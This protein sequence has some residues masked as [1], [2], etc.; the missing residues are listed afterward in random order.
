MAK[1]KNILNIKADE[2]S[3]GQ[4]L[5]HKQ[6]SF[7]RLSQAD[8]KTPSQMTTGAE[9]SSDVKTTAVS[10]CK[11]SSKSDT[12]DGA[13]VLRALP[14]IP[15]PNEEITSAVTTFKR[16]LAREWKPA[17]IPPPRGTLIVS[18]IVEI[19]GPNGRCTL[20]VQAA[21]H[22]AQSRWVSLAMGVRRIYPKKKGPRGGH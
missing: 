14:P 16:T 10:T 3:T 4:H 11:A 22:P 2:S 12:K 5:P 18:G 17:G 6:I 21:Y 7:H 19:K 15:Q 8:E 20:E 9:P 1:L 13:K